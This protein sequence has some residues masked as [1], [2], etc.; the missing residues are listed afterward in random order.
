[1][2]PP[3]AY[4]TLP[5]VLLTVLLAAPRVAADVGDQAPRTVVIL[6]FDGFAPSLLRSTPAPALERMRKEGAWTDRMIPP[7][8]TISFISQVTI[9]TGC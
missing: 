7:F 6:L 4:A 8:P 2:R 3:I 9:S 5:V 1:M